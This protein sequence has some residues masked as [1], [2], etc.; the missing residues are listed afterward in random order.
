MNGTEIKNQIDD[1]NE[2][3]A[4]NLSLSFFVLNKKVQEARQK[5]EYL[6]GICSHIYGDDDTC[7]Y[8]RKRR[9]E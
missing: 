3:I 7:I 9:E 2:F 6:Q 5:I 8:C 4:N 1:L